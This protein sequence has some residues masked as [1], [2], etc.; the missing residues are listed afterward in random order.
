MESIISKLFN[1]KVEVDVEKL[2]LTTELS[3]RNAVIDSHLLAL[4]ASQNQLDSLQDY[5]SKVTLVDLNRDLE[6]S[7]EIK[8]LESY[9]TAYQSILGTNFHLKFQN[10][11]DINST[12]RIS[13]FILFPLVQN[14][15]HF[16][17]NSMEKYP[18]RVKLGIVGNKIKLEVSNRANHHIHSQELTTL[19]SNF[20]SRLLLL[21]PESHELLINSNSMLFKAT[22]LVGYIY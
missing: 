13:P 3:M 20:K 8:N 5:L 11:I 1:K 17:Y 6:L 14:S 21:H 7:K 9:I 15:I 4:A 12:I 10:N 16:G 2:Q 22:L 19:I 18:I